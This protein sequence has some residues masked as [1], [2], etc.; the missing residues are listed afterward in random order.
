MAARIWV[1]CALAGGC[2]TSAPPP[3]ISNATPPTAR[4]VVAATVEIWTGVGVQ[5][6]AASEW[7]I[8]MRINR[9]AAVGSRLG[10]IDYPSLGCSSDLIRELDRGATIV[11]VERLRVNPENACVDGGT[12][13]LRDDGET[14][15]WRWFYEDGHEGASSTLRRRSS[16]VV[17]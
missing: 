14:L 11:A 4:P 9:A 8:E 2:F 10:T 3:P 12:I 5:P 15:D 16:K 7:T 6:D 1:A 17:Q 13:V